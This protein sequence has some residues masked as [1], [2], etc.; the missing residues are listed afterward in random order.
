MGGHPFPEIP[1]KLCSKPVDLK[2]DLSAD[3][4]GKSVHEDCYVK[5]LTRSPGS[6]PAMMVSD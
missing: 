5:H 3:E 2:V 1:C 4:N 6:V